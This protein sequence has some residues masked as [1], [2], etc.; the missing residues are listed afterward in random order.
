[1]EWI[2]IIEKNITVHR[3]ISS[4]LRLNLTLTALPKYY[5]HGECYFYIAVAFARFTI[6]VHALYSF[7]QHTS[8]DKFAIAIKKLQGVASTSEVGSYTDVP[9]SNVYGQSI[10]K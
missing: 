4:L 6:A 8:R 3:K 9:A 10:G 5:K 2:R 1:M 7:Q